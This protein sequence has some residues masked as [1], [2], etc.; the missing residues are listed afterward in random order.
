[1]EQLLQEAKRCL[2]TDQPRMAVLYMRKALALLEAQREPV[3]EPW[4]DTF[5]RFAEVFSARFQA[6]T[7]HLIAGFAYEPGQSD[8]ALAAEP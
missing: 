3:Q 4:V 7:E 6:V 2:A 1:M 8:F 5:L